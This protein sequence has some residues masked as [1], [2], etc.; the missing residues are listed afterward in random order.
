[1]VV[2]T[3]Q[4][5]SNVLRTATSRTGCIDFAV[6]ALRLRGFGQGR[7]EPR[8]APRPSYRALLIAISGD[9]APSVTKLRKE[10][11]SRVAGYSDPARSNKWNK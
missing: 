5:L 2:W 11:A 4:T 1:M 9:E 8:E 3:L 6:L 10:A 7:E